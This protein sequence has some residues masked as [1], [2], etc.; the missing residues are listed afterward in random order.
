MAVASLAT[1]AAANMEINNAATHVTGFLIELGPLSP[2][3]RLVPTQFVAESLGD[4]H[5]MA[6]TFCSEAFV[7]PDHRSR[8][9]V[10]VRIFAQ[11]DI[12]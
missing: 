11:I 3:L 10:R 5:E 2:L 9:F 12:E 6:L 8:Q 1:A 4:S 7:G